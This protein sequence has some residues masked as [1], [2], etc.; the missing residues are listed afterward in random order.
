MTSLLGDHGLFKVRKKLLGKEK[1]KH[2]RK[3]KSLDLV[4][5]LCS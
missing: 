4:A 5:H 3:S 1:K 2:P